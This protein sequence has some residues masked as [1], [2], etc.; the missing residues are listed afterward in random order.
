MSRFNSGVPIYA[1]SRNVHTLRRLSLFREVNVMPLPDQDMTH[2]KAT[3][4]IESTLIKQGVL[5]HGDTA[6]ITYGSNMGK[7]GAS[8]TMRIR[9]IGG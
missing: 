3:T 5:K 6:V 7:V 9:R 4:L 8:D 2:E 1:F